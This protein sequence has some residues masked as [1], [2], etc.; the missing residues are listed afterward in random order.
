MQANFE[1][2]RLT[3]DCTARAAGLDPVVLTGA[4][5]C[6]GIFALGAVLSAL[7]PSGPRFR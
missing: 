5:I 4:A 2:A 7:M 6:I 3:I 1:C